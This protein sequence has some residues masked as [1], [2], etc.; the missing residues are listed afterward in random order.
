MTPPVPAGLGAVEEQQDAETATALVQDALHLRVADA[1]GWYSTAEAWK[2]WDVRACE[3]V[4][5]LPTEPDDLDELRRRL[6]AY[7]APT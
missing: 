6:L 3:F 2:R 4:Q 7:G 1:L 5:S